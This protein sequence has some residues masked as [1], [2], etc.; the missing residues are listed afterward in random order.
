MA[1]EKGES[2]MRLSLVWMINRMKQK[3]MYLRGNLYSWKNVFIFDLDEGTF[4]VPLLSILLS[5]NIYP[6]RIFT[7]GELLL[8]EN[9]TLGEH[10]LSENI[11]S[12]RTFT[13]GALLL[14]ENFTLG[15]L[16]S[17]GTFNFVLEI[18][19]VRKLKSLDLRITNHISL[20]SR[21]FKASTTFL[22]VCF[23]LRQIMLFCLQTVTL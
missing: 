19:R 21:L 16:Y 5:E 22:F 23:L 20:I 4:N 14:S 2:K 8:L 6:W 3:V 1:R 13:F 15:E 18:L 7:L 11:Y 10:L 12:R 17:Q 9:F